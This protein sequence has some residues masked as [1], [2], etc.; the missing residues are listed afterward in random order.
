MA[1]HETEITFLRQQEV[2]RHIVEKLGAET[3]FIA[4]QSEQTER[5]S[6]IY[7]SALIPNKEVAAAMKTTDWDLHTHDTMPVWWSS[8]REG[9]QIDHYRRF[10]GDRGVEP[11][12]ICRNFHGLKQS[13]REVCEEFRL[14]HNLYHDAANKRYVA[15]DDGGNEEDIIQYDDWLIKIKT[16]ALLRYI[17][18]KQCHLAVFFESI[19]YSEFSLTELKRK[20]HQQRVQTGVI[21]Y[22]FTIRDSEMLLDEKK[23]STS[24][25]WGK[26][27]IPPEKQLKKARTPKEPYQDFIIGR[28]PDGSSVLNTCDPEQLANYFGKNPSAPHYLTPVHFR[29]EVL[30]KYFGDPEKYSVED[31]YL[32]CGSLWGLRLDNNHKGYVTVFLGDLG[33]DLT[34]AERDYWK[35]FNIPPEGPG[36]SEVN[37]KRGFMAEFADPTQPGL[38]FKELFSYFQREHREQQGW[39]IFKDLADEDQHF[40]DALRAPLTRGPAEFDSQVLALTKV[41]VDSINE[42]D[43]EKRITNLTEGDKGIAKLEK[44]LQ[45]KNLVGYEAHSQFLRNL[46]KL[47]STG[48]AHRKGE[49]FKKVATSF[50]LDKNDRIKVFE[51]ILTKSA[52]FMEFLMAGFLIKK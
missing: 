1:N 19:R 48:V 32:R 12:V 14:Y 29:P 6:L 2:E 13:Y 9:Y 25:I 52:E 51:D 30:Q 36:I 20:P 7:F 34:N 46:Q 47:R 21:L 41:I 50:G 45:S 40:F 22:D 35:S 49:N 23:K 5:D 33:R 39:T 38:R 15:H 24:C 43:L 11:L 18:D 26:K 37:W 27:L 28:K 4:H 44:F 10:G 17:A 42:E 8:S 3:W 16:H 31:G